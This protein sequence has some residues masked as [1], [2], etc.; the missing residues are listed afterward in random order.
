MFKGI[1]N[2]KIQ[3]NIK[4]VVP[5][6]GKDSDFLGEV[7]FSCENSIVTM[8]VSTTD[9]SL[10]IMNFKNGIQYQANLIID[11][12]SYQEG[13]FREVELHTCISD[14]EV[15]TFQSNHLNVGGYE[16]TTFDSKEIVKLFFK[17]PHL[18]NALSSFR[19]AMRYPEDRAVFCYRAVEN[20]RHHFT[21]SKDKG[22]AESWERMRDSLGISKETMVALSKHSTPARHG[23]IIDI[24]DD[25]NKEIVQIAITVI[26]AFITYLWE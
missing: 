21:N 8:T 23:N 2:P 12:Y 15:Y 17:S 19:K 4:V 3:K 6:G 18:A 26:D 1:V 16:K 11:A 22:K 25:L 24:S 10:S 14:E 20:I 9:E 5:V 13:I 7:D